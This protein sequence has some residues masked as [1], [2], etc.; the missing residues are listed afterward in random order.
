MTNYTEPTEDQIFYLKMYLRSNIESDQQT[1][2]ERCAT[3]GID[4]DTARA[5]AIASFNREHAP[6][7][8]PPVVKLA[9]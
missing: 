4:Y 9:A 3:Y 7:Q 8:R 5:A 6:Q 2:R 1:A